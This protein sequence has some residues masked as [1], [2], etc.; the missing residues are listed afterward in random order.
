MSLM[1]DFDI[2]A[3]QARIHAEETRTVA[4]SFTFVETRRVVLAVADDYDKRASRYEQMAR[5]WEQRKEARQ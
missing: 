3:N 2:M 4:E 1:N 5:L